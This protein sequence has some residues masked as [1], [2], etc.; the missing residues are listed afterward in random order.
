MVAAAWMVLPIRS[1]GLYVDAA[2]MTNLETDSES[3]PSINFLPTINRVLMQRYIK[4]SI[5][6]H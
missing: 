5:F 6:V 2:G 3:M 1:M 4:G